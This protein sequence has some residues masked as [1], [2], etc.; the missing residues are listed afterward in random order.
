[1]SGILGMESQKP[2]PPLSEVRED[3]I[4]VIADRPPATVRVRRSASVQQSKVI[5]LLGRIIN[6]HT[7]IVK[8]ETSPHRSPTRWSR[9]NRQ[10]EVYLFP[11]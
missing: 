1:M 8:A 11:C 10:A 7:V 6:K 4:A 2:E 3:T 9:L 5:T